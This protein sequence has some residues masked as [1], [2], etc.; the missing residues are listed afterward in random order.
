M[1]GVYF[2][3]LCPKNMHN[4]VLGVLLDLLENPKAIPHVTA[5]HGRQDISAAHLLCNI[6]RDEEQEIGVPREKTGAIQGKTM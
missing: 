2:F 1:V 4:L 5:W 6:W 3:Q